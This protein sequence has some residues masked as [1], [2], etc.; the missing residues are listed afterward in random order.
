[1]W[2][3]SIERLIPPDLTPMPTP[4]SNRPIPS[5]NVGDLIYAVWEDSVG[6]PRGW[7]LGE[8]AM[9]RKDARVESV[10]G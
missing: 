6:C 3:H 5:P 2:D 7:E 4:P 9:A 8:D 10:G 1:M